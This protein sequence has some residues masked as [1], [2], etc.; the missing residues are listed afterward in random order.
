[1]KINREEE[2]GGKAHKRRLTL[3][4]KKDDLMLAFSS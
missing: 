2:H 1:V 4:P 3:K